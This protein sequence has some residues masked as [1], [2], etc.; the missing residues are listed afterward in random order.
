MGLV[1]VGLNHETAPVEL[2]EKV[3][4][5]PEDLKEALN[6]LTR[7][8]D[9]REL[10][11][12]STCNRTELVA[13]VPDDDKG[14]AN[15][16]SFLAD[17]AGVP[18]SEIREHIYQFWGLK[19]VEHI[20]SVASGLESMVLGEPQITGQVKDAFDRA[21]EA[22]TAGKRLSSIYR[23]TIQTVK[24]VRTQ[25]EIARNAVSISYVAVELAR[26]VF[27]ELKGKRALLVGAGEMCELAATHLKERG[28]DAVDV[29]NRTFSRAERLASRF[30]GHPYP[31][32]NLREALEVA[33]IVVS[34]TGSP[35]SIIGKADVEA[36]LRK[37]KSASLLLI[38]IAVPRDIEPEV[39]D[40]PGVF[41]FDIDDLQKVIEANK[42]KRKKEAEKAAQLIARRVREYEKWRRMQDVNPVIVELRQNVEAMRKEELEKSLKNL[43]GCS[44]EV[45]RELDRLS[46]SVMNKMLH[47][48]ITELK[49]AAREENLE[50]G[51]VSFFRSIFKLD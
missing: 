51:L 8:S 24:Q 26:K 17:R 3:G 45:R 46:Y 16:V 5:N 28:V 25:T 50:G 21:I 39:G 35:E 48:P 23:H 12:L 44:E 37:R 42:E 49:R 33:D 34:S 7:D 6:K 1:L 18:L 29:T 10:V 47:Q 15:L 30:D 31:L 43:H 22:G 41:L 38:D 19:A 20:F 36:A 27:G 2:R 4:L 32:G 13:F 40:L 9:L 14:E 11:I